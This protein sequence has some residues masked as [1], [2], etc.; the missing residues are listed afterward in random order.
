MMV[1]VHL[2]SVPNVTVVVH[3][4]SAPNVPRRLLIGHLSKQHLLAL[5]VIALTRPLLALA[6]I[7][8]R[9]PLLALAV[10]VPMSLRSLP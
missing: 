5:A 2:V 4:V 1:A 6:V 3:L 7:A 9:R 8:L 10:I